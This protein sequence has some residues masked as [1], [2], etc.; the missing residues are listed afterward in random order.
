MYRPE[1]FVVSLRD[2]LVAASVSVTVAPATDAPAGS[3]TAPCI[4]PVEIACP[5]A[6]IGINTQ[7]STNRKQKYT[8]LFRAKTH[9][10]PPRQAPALPRHF[11]F[12]TPPQCQILALAY[13]SRSVLSSRKLNFCKLI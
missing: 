6:G 4:V 3:V 5:R 10:D 12:L 2:V 13:S 1:S 9:I 8:R 7:I 11:L